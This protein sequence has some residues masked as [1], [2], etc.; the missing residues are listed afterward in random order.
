MQNEDENNQNKTPEELERIAKA[1]KA[2]EASA[3]KLAAVRALK[4]IS[5]PNSKWNL[6]QELFQEICALHVVNDPDK[7]PTTSKLKDQ[8][9]N[10]INVRYENEPETKQL[11]LDAIPGDRFIKGWTKKEGWQEAVWEK[12]KIR[13]L[14]TEEKRAQVIEALRQR[15]MTRDT[16]AA[17]IWLT[18]SGDYS[19]KMDISGDKAQDFYREI[20][21][22]LHGK[23]NS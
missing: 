23:K 6:L 14:F 18:L 19:E 4:E 9:I 8:L 7:T 5:N 10:E 16:Q 21:K 17:K 13:G 2:G 11:L 3:I 20:N 22:I 12:I 1:A 15:A